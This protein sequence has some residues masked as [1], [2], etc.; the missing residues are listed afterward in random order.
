MPRAL[1]IAEGDNL[2]INNAV[3]EKAADAP[4]IGINSNAATRLA[5]RTGNL[6]LA[7]LILTKRAVSEAIDGR[8]KDANIG[9]K[10]LHT[11]NNGV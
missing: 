3:A 6:I 7:H 4:T 11:L 2:P 1:A 8:R 9:N 5:E 10:E